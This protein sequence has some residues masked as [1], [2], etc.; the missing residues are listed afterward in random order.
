[1]DGAETDAV[2]GQIKEKPLSITAG[3]AERPSLP[4]TMF[5]KVGECLR[6]QSCRKVLRTSTESK[7]FTHHSC[8]RVLAAG[9][10]NGQIFVFGFDKWKTDA[11]CTH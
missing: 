8:V 6:R 11:H 5:H 1:M 2:S 4:L 10:Q 3:E 7:D 9:K